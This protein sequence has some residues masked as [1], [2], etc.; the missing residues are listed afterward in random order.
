MAARAK[1][2]GL[3]LAIIKKII[4]D[5]KAQLGLENL[6]EGGA[7]VTLVFKVDDDA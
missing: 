1:G 4:D 3:R 7:C 5:H 6:S 2:N